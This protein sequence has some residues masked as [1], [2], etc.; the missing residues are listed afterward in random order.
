MKI[1]KI[2]NEFE[3]IIVAIDGYYNN[4]TYEI[5]KNDNITTIYYN[6]NSIDYTALITVLELYYDY[7]DE[8]YTHLLVPS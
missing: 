3:I 7:I 4:T 5:Q 8:Y 6:H 2:Y 1:Q